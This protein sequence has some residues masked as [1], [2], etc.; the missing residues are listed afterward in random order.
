MLRDRYSPDSMD[1]FD[2][3]DFEP[4]IAVG[5][6]RESDQTPVR[7]VF[8]NYLVVIAGADAG[9]R[10]EISDTPITIGRDARQTLVF[11]DSQLSRLHTRVSLV[12]GEVVAEDLKSTN[13]TFI[14]GIRLTEPATMREGQVM[15]VG[16]Q[17]LTYERRSRRDIDRAEELDRD[18]RRASQ[19][20]FSLLP[21]P[22]TSGLVRAHWRFVPSTQLGGDAF[23]YYWLDPQTFVFYLLD[24]SGHGA[25]SAMHSV[26][27]LNV[28]RQRALPDVDF[29]N[30]A[31]VLTSLNARF[32]MD[33]HG[34]LF[35]TMWYGMYDTRDRTLK[36]ASAG[37]HPAFLVTPERQASQP[38]GMPAL[39]IGAFQEYEY[40]VDQTT[41]PPDSTVYLF[42]DGV[43]EIV[44]KDKLRWE[45]TNFLPLLIDPPLP[46]VPE[47]ERLH[48]SVTQTAESSHLEDD[49]SLM[50]VTF[51]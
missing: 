23:G 18:L 20:V 26:T 16:S 24:V 2:T 27:V 37:H 48:R 9:K 33:S 7:E 3:N 36:Y 1:P 32:S 10:I 14:D 40:S 21:E 13:G 41:V 15:R 8:G 47:A 12:N 44:T 29:R 31:A 5:T 50:V 49:F 6:K 28:L 19:Y 38:L 34:G 25:G 51:P 11:D 35:F 17:L 42:S 46:G 45:M 30:P 39:M 4:T 22:I 43:F